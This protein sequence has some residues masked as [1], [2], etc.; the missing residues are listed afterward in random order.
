MKRCLADVNVLL[1]LLVR[2]HEHHRT[3][4]KWFE[5]LAAGEAGLCRVV[6]LSLIRLLGNASIMRER[7]MAAASA[8]IVIEQLLEDERVD[9][10]AEP[11]SLDAAFPA[12]L[13]YPVPTGKLVGD[14]Y[15]AAFAIADSRRMVTLDRGFRQYKG[16]NV[17]LLGRH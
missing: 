2:H 15:L 9:L 11:A 12:F 6:Q 10:I 7:V 16:L 13:K 8:W 3:A 5:E 14:A 1:A 17:Q 4:L